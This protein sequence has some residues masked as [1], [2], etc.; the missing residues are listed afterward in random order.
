MEYQPLCGDEIRLLTIHP[1]TDT[2]SPVHVSLH[3]AS[4]GIEE[5]TASPYYALSYC[6]GDPADP[7]EITLN[8]VQVAV[9]RNL[10]RALRRFR[11]PGLKRPIWID[12]LC[13]NQQDL[14]ERSVQVLRMRELYSRAELVL[15]WLGQDFD[16]SQAAR[17]WT[18]H[19]MYN[20]TEEQIGKAFDLLDFAAS[21]TQ[22]ASSQPGRRALMKGIESDPRRHGLLGLSFFVLQSTYWTRTWIVQELVLARNATIYCGARQMS[23]EAFARAVDRL[24]RA[25]EY[26]RHDIPHP[27][28]LSE[29]IR[30]VQNVLDIWSA[31]EQRMSGNAMPLSVLLRVT[32]DKVATDPRDS[33]YGLLGLADDGAKYVSS[34][35][36]ACSLEEAM[37]SFAFE[38]MRSR[39]ILHFFY[40]RQSTATLSNKRSWAPELEDIRAVVRCPKQI[41]V[42]TAGIGPTQRLRFDSTR[43]LM[44]LLGVRVDTIGK[45]TVQRWRDIT[46]HWSTLQQ[47]DQ[48][49]REC[50]AWMNE[51]LEGWKHRSPQMSV[52]SPYE[53][54]AATHE[55]VWRSLFQNATHDGQELPLD[56]A[57]RLSY[58]WPRL[59]PGYKTPGE[60]EATATIRGWLLDN[61]DFEIGGRSLHAWTAAPFATSVKKS[62]KQKLASIA[63]I[64]SAS[65]AADFL[66]RKLQD[67][68]PAPSRA[69]DDQVYFLDSL[70]DITERRLIVTQRGYVGNVSFRAKDG[71]TICALFGCN[72]LVV[73]RPDGG[74]FRIVGDAYVHGFMNGEAVSDLQEAD[75][76]DFEIW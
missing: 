33:I 38:A 71:D 73:L 9:T 51:H 45:S 20:C 5:T 62:M 36:Y 28:K 23:W 13:I 68:Y 11:S 30:F 67:D 72:K 1:A 53:S 52:P 42:H 56:W 32:S 27:H 18:N 59:V 3:H 70:R 34:P 19:W 48:N 57:S 14:A 61:R 65:K 6:W 60:R 58:F 7:P 75:I 43:H 10:H 54:P 47:F 46:A 8:G 25:Y 69:D 21:E 49:P 66:S 41:L 2:D 31:Y 22:S 37:E 76:E 40:I 26:D 15:V 29:W 64:P 12:A 4:L 55:A 16:T 35:D 24:D 39:G 63:T 50:Q 17:T 44:K 74:K